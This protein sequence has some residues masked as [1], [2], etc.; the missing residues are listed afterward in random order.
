M[1]DAHAHGAHGAERL[2]RLAQAIKDWREQLRRGEVASH[3]EQRTQPP[4][5][6]HAR[7]GR[8]GERAFVAAEMRGDGPRIGLQ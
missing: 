1:Q 4:E 5:R 3:A 7:L 8:R 6:C 2:A